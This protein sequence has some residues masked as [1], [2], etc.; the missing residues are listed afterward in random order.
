MKHSL[1][2]FFEDFWCKI[3]MFWYVI[4]MF[5]LLGVF[6]GWPK[7]PGLSYAEFNATL[8]KYGCVQIPMF[9][10]DEY[11]GPQAQYQCGNRYFLEYQLRDISLRERPAK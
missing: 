4:L 10:R 6:I 9:Y 8:T 2:L 1:K 7:A 5:L 3:L 11:L